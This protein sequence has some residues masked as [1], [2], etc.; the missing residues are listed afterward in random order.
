MNSNLNYM[1]KLF[2]VVIFQ[3]DTV[4]KSY[5]GKPLANE[6]KISDSNVKIK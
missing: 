5:A 4:M 6:F 2:F 3:Y 1:E